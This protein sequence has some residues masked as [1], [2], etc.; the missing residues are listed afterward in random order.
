MSSMSSPDLQLVERIKA[1]RKSDR[2][3]AATLDSLGK[4]VETGTAQWLENGQRLTILTAGLM[5]VET[6][7][8]G[9]YEAVLGRQF[10]PIAAAIADGVKLD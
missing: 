8:E 3:Y 7:D 5:A 10:V 1:R 6:E 4:C 9:A 2:L